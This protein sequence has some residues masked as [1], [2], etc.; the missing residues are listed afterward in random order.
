[1]KDS[2]GQ[3]PSTAPIVPSF[4]MTTTAQIYSTAINPPPPPSS[5]PPA[6]PPP[7]TAQTNTQQKSFLPPPPGTSDIQGGEMD[8]EL[9]DD[10]QDPNAH[11]NITNNFIP[12]TTASQAYNGGLYDENFVAQNQYGEFLLNFLLH[13]LYLL[14]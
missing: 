13:V 1:M 12:P 6:T 3:E 8:M 11:N 2:P 7:H 4:P 14:I 5:S 10:Q 9:D